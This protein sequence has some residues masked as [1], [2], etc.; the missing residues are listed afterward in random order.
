MNQITKRSLIAAGVVTGLILIAGGAVISFI[1][2]ISS[3]TDE[4]KG[5]PFKIVSSSPQQ[6][7]VVTVER[8]WLEHTEENPW[9]WEIYLAYAS[10]GQEVLNEAGVDI[11]EWSSNPYWTES[12]QLDW[13][14][15]N[16]FRLAD[17]ASL[18]E[19]ECDVLL[20]RNDSTKAISY[21]Y[22]GGEAKER[23][24][25]LNLE[26]QAS[27]KLHARP[28]L[29][30]DYRSIFASGRFTSGGKIDALRSFRFPR[31]AKGPGRY[32]LSVKE[33]MTTIVS[34]DFE[35]VSNFTP[36]QER[37]ITE[38]FKKREAGQATQADRKAVDEIYSNRA[39]IT[40]PKA[41]DC[42]PR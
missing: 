25:I 40:I 17:S 38:Y 24:F 3:L 37:K 2:F 36:E 6:N 29:R 20:V 28:Q 5:P 41:P 9:D 31:S 13:I 7:Y 10:Q 21:L 34:L 15:E 23:F 16:T 30:G 11:G 35:G 4:P 39:E 12:P 8:K 18:P 19:S 33:D 42:G 14:H 26:P 27:L 1:S 22:V 32:C